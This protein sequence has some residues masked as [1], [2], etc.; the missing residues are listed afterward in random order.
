MIGRYPKAEAFVFDLVHEQC[1]SAQIH[2]SYNSSANS[3]D[4][5]LD[6]EDR[7]PSL[8]VR[9]DGD[10]MDDLEEALRNGSLLHDE[11]LKNAVRFTAY[12]SL[13][14]VGRMPKGFPISEILVKERGDWK[15]DLKITTDFDDQFTRQLVEG[16]GK[17]H[18]FLEKHLGENQD[19]GDRLDTLRSAHDWIADLMRYY[20]D[21]KHLNDTGVSTETLT[22]FKAAIVAQLIE[23]EARRITQPLAEI[24][25]AIDREVYTLVEK[26]RNSYFLHVPLPDWFLEYREL[27]LANAVQIGQIDKTQSARSIE[28]IH[29][30]LSHKHDDVGIADAIKQCL[31][32]FGV[33][34]FVAHRDINPSA[35]WRQTI[36]EHLQGKCNA[37]APLLTNEFHG[38]LWTDQETGIAV[39]QNLPIAPIKIHRDPYGFID[40]RQAVPLKVGEYLK[41]CIGL[42]VGLGI[43]HLV[44]GRAARLCLARGLESS[45]TYDEAGQIAEVLHRL[46]PFTAEE[47][48]AVLRAVTGNRQAHESQSA[49]THLRA[50]LD[51]HR[52]E[53]NGELVIQCDELVGAKTIPL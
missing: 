48:T 10:R 42:L 36:L 20:R 11:V 2:P 37:F 16:L 22:F 49:T 50:F 3:F 40:D 17:L 44:F 23:K 34:A 26:L 4:Y 14:K 38:S 47:A 13:G 19:L 28:T 5:R 41:M 18:H 30:F 32:K 27:I 43:Q 39:Q 51:N 25:A 24:R 21:K 9:F 12:I 1:A 7:Q 6:F 29:V 31:E 52:S 33:E 35:R 45:Q 53:L 8:T 46:E 15:Y